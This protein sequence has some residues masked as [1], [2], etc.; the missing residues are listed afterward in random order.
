MPSLEELYGEVDN[1][2]GLVHPSWQRSFE[3]MDEQA[4]VAL[5][6][7]ITEAIAAT[8]MQLVLVSQTGAHPLAEICQ[9]IA[10]RRGYKLVWKPVKFPREPMRNILPVLSHYLS[11]HEKLTRLS[12]RAVQALRYNVLSSSLPWSQDDTRLEALERVCGSMPEQLFAGGPA[13]LRLLLLG[14]GSVRQTPFQ[15]ACSIVF[16]GTEIANQL[17]QPFIY[18]DEYIDS[19]TTFR[20]TLAFLRCFAPQPLLRTVSYFINLAEYKNYDPVVFT[21]ISAPK[22]P[23]IFEA[24]A[25]PYEN[26]IDLIG[27]F[28]RIASGEFELF[29]VQRICDRFRE[30]SERSSMSF[31]SQLSEIVSDCHVYDAVTACFSLPEVRKFVT[32]DHVLRYC[33]FKLE[34]KTGSPRT[35]EFLYQLFDMYG[36]AWSPMPVDFH[37]DFWSGFEQADQAIEQVLSAD[38]L[39][40]E[41]VSCRGNLLYEAARICTQRRKTW[42]E[43]IDKKLEEIYVTTESFGNTRAITYSGFYSR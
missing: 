25:Y 18:L 5:A 28:Y 19:G 9:K 26:R 43:L 22:R 30:Q 23:E 38:S 42:Q 39:V 12:A 37:F 8:G 7:K 16:E 34:Q 3:Y 41:Y 1:L 15:S 17:A 35:A 29:E 40:Q 13:D 24:G 6:E 14:I 4:A 11:P 2:S 21:H 31:L 10:L 36:P 32:R 20:N 33:L 27:H